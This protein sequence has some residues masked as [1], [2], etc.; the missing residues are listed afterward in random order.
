MPF[1]VYFMLFYFI[2]ENKSQCK[3]ESSNFLLSTLVQ[4]IHKISS[5][6][7]VLF[8]F[9]VNY[10][11]TYCVYV[12]NCLCAV[13]FVALF[14]V[15]FVFWNNVLYNLGWPWTCLVIINALEFLILLVNGTSLGARINHGTPDQIRLISCWNSNPG[16][17]AC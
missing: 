8:C 17:H 9:L 7:F 4:D 15:C 5:R 14:Y 10:Y 3:T 11:F 13:T 6:K 2:V 1:K 12:H 16:L